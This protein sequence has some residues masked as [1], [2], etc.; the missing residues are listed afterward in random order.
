MSP[1]RSSTCSSWR[2]SAVTH[3]QPDSSCAAATTRPRAANE[4]DSQCC[5]AQ[6]SDAARRQH[7]ARAVAPGRATLARTN[8]E[9][10]GT[11]GRVGGC[12]AGPCVTR[13]LLPPD[14]RHAAE[15]RDLNA[16]RSRSCFV[17]RLAWL[18]PTSRHEQASPVWCT[19]VGAEQRRDERRTSMPGP[20]AR[21]VARVDAR[22]R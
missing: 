2:S 15:S 12:T 1:L 11:R 4:E 21:A 7:K 9:A 10:L 17:R 19:C 6:A 22:Q 8:S 3:L 20:A 14:R 5:Q 18:G 16:T 13:R